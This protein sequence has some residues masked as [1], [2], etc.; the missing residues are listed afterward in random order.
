MA[1]ENS[2]LI[3][4]ANVKES[5][6][7]LAQLLANEPATVTLCTTFDT[8]LPHLENNPM[9]S[10]LLKFKSELTEQGL[11]D[12]ASVF[13]DKIECS[14]LLLSGKVFLAITRQMITGGYDALICIRPNRTPGTGLS[15]TEMHLARKCPGPVL[16]L[17]RQHR[18]KLENI[19][20][21]VDRD[22]YGGG[23][24]SALAQELVKI[25]TNLASVDGANLHIVH[26]WQPLGVELLGDPRLGFESQDIENYR[27]EQRASHD[28]WLKE[29]V[30]VSAASLNPTELI[31]SLYLKE[32][33]AD[34][35]ILEICEKT[36]SDLLVIGTVGITDVPGVLIGDVAET[37]LSVAPCSM[38]A[39]KPE[40]FQTPIAS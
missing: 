30:A 31:T 16:F 15:A 32:G 10:Q 22:V 36:N 18:T 19:M 23:S 17:D 4:I 1:I 37:I 13:G 21:G 34:K 2:D 7:L 14:T 25:A 29:L 20:V 6:S 40:G 12:C 26:A 8:E 5:I 39:M 33:E 27:A 24:A 9:A 35:V 3:D 11:E 38:L 28:K